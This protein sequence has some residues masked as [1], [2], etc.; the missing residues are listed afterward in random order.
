MEINCFIGPVFSKSPAGLLFFP[1][2]LNLRQ[3]EIF[4]P[5]IYGADAVQRSLGDLLINAL[6]LCWVVLFAWS[7]LRYIENPVSGLSLKLRW[8]LGLLA[9]CT[10]IYSSFVLANV[11]RSLVSDSKISFDV[12]N[13]FSLD[14]YT[15]AGFVVLACLSLSYYYLSQLLFRFIFLCLREEIILFISQLG[16]PD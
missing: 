2:L 5:V 10:L 4:N 12:T 14:W 8:L 9:L 16:L 15:V 3:F 11:V 1:S 7:K 13:F 6:L